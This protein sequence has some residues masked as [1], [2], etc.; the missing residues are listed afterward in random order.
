MSARCSLYTGERL[1]LVMASTPTEKVWWLGV[2]Y[3]GRNIAMTIHDDTPVPLLGNGPNVSGLA[4]PV[5][6][7]RGAYDWIDMTV[8][9]NHNNK[10]MT[11]WRLSFCDTSPS[12]KSLLQTHRRQQLKSSKKHVC[13]GCTSWCGSMVPTNEREND[14]RHRTEAINNTI[15]MVRL[16]KASATG[17]E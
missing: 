8:I 14:C 4:S 3:A 15:L 5:N 16:M 12:S 17:C 2:L 1:Q 9:S 11:E 13:H 6:L 10:N 7:P